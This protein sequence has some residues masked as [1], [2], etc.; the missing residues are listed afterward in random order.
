MTPERKRARDAEVK[1]VREHIRCVVLFGSLSCK[2]VQLQSAG[3][4]LRML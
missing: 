2:I 4:G 3:L 1:A